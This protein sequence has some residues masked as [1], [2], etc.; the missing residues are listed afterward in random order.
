MYDR[1]PKSILDALSQGPFAQSCTINLHVAA[2]DLSPW[3]DWLHPGEG[4]GRGQKRGGD[5]E[6]H[7]ENPQNAKH[8]KCRA[9]KR[10]AG[11]ESMHRWGLFVCKVRPPRIPEKRI[12]QD[13]PESPKPAAWQTWQEVAALPQLLVQQQSCEARARGREGTPQGSGLCVTQ[14]MDEQ[15]SWPSALH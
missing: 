5:G 15:I 11:D 10:I 3:S 7:T 6:E 13:T 14:T 2:T 8:F 4:A 12:K 1:G 9:G